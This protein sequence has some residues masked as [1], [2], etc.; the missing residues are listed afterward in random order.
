M[1]CEIG[2]V[3]EGYVCMYLDGEN[4]SEKSFLELLISPSKF[5]RYEMVRNAAN[6]FTL[7]ITKPPQR[8]R[9]VTKRSHNSAIVPCSR[10]AVD[11]WCHADGNAVCGDKPC[12]LPARHQ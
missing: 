7:C 2:D 4:Y 1:K 9:Q 5:S 8:Q 3:G 11:S 6:T 12:M 10:W